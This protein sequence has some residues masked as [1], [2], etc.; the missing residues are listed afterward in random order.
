MKKLLVTGVN[1]MLGNSI[2][3]E[4][5]HKYTVAGIHRDKKCWAE[6]DIEYRC[7]IRDRKKIRDILD[8][9]RPDVIIHCAGLVNMDL[10]EEDPELAYEVNVVGTRNLVGLENGNSKYIYISTDQVY[11]ASN[12]HSET[13]TNLSQLNEYGKTKYLGEKEFTDHIDD[14]IVIRTNI[15]GWNKKPG[16]LNS[17]EW[18]YMSIK[19][20]N[21]LYLFDD[22]YF[23]PIY[24]LH[25]CNAVKKLLDIDF[26][27][28]INIGAPYPCSKYEFGKEM[29]RELG[30]DDSV[31]ERGSIEAFNFKANRNH[32]LSLNTEMA[33]NLGIPL[34]DWKNSIASFI[35][36]NPI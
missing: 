24:S 26:I 4:L 22:Y 12:D 11:G 28:T 5:K 8:N 2:C 23:S 21:K 3:K 30:A 27:G 1:G 9:V 17:S 34:P 33:K 32:D 6:V 35:N 14:H 25:F 19:K 15:F 31:L 29:C 36:E 10:C 18:M 16:K 13:N 20:K 7:D